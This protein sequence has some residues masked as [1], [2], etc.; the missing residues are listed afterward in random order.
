MNNMN[1]KELVDIIAFNTRYT[2]K[3]VNEIIGELIH[4]IKVNTV[5]NVNTT[6]IGFGTFSRVLRASRIGVNPNT[7]AK[8]KI[9]CKYVPNFKAGKVFKMVVR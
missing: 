9:P 4:Q 1:R 8:I 2:K 3:S 7:G 5:E 6:L